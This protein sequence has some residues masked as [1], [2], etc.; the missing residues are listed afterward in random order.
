MPP[1]QICPPPTTSGIGIPLVIIAGRVALH[2]L[3]IR[4]GQHDLLPSFAGGRSG[5]IR[6]IG[7]GKENQKGKG[8]EKDEDGGGE[9]VEV[10]VAV[11][12][13]VVV[14]GNLAEHLHAD[15]GVDE[16]EQHNEQ[17][18]VGKGP[19]GKRKDNEERVRRG[20]GGGGRSLG[21]IS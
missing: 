13:G 21:R 11:D 2:L 7:S 1:W 6:R 12:L 3:P 19:K 9:S 18:H 16:E 20:K 5:N 10:V 8:P 4:A 15:D 17:G 14:Q